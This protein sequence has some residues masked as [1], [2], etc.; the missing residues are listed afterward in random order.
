[1]AIAWVVLVSIGLSL[2]VLIAGSAIIGW[3]VTK[4]LAHRIRTGRILVFTMAGMLMGM[5]VDLILFLLALVFSSGLLEMP[6]GM[7]GWMNAVL[8]A[9]I[10]WFYLTLAG[11][12]AG[13]HVTRS[14]KTISEN[15]ELLDKIKNPPCL[16]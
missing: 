1:M 15:P 5:I 10:P 12:V 13:M 9:S 6:R 16:S 2:P 3:W 11:L 7:G 4:M 8:A 14:E